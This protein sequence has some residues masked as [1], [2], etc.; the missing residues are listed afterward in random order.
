MKTEPDYVAF[1]AL[2][3]GNQNH[4]FARRFAGTTAEECGQ[5]PANAEALHGWLEALHRRCAG[6]V[7]IAIEAGGN[8]VLQALLEYPWLTI[9]PIHSAASARF[10]RA[11]RP[12]GAKDDEPDALMLL[13]LLCLHRRQ[14]SAL[15]VDTPATRKLAALA[16][17]RRVTVDERTRLTNR[18]TSTL[19][20]YFPQAL[21]LVGEELSAPLAC[22]FLRR[23]PEL[24]AVQKVRPASLR[25]FYH[26]HHVRSE[27]RIAERLALVRQARPLHR[28][29]AVIEPAVLE[30]AMLVEQLEMQARQISALDQHLAAAFA[31]HPQAAFFSALPGAGAVLAPR[32]LVAF[33][34]HPERYPDAGALQKYAGVAPVREKSGR[35]LWTHW[36]WNAPT[37]L[38]QS[39]VEWA[40]QTVVHCSWA[41]AYYHRQK[42]SGKSHQAILRALAFKWIR[43]LWRCRR[44]HT[45][46]DEQRYLEALRQ[47]RSPLAAALL[48]S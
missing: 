27:E 26:R 6:P 38:R 13:H 22:A 46:Y 36:R 3:W 11:F 18:L 4:A 37:F 15:R 19:K 30:V 28:D 45:P 12:S 39:F 1:V 7:A 35:H 48:S 21:A 47:K 41:R 25:A 23:F 31:A 20:S 9:Y 44:D 24:A 14:L 2:D 17:M 16:R 10:R 43:I 33:G 29:R 32:L 34:D 42:C 8:S 5:F 40:G